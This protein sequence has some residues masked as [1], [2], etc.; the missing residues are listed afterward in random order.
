MNKTL[1]LL[2]QVDRVGQLLAGENTK[3]YYLR[4]FNFKTDS[5]YNEGKSRQFLKLK[6]LSSL[7]QVFQS[8]LKPTILSK[9]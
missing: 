6:T 1:N 2:K 3:S 7:H 4:V 9:D 8:L 5:F